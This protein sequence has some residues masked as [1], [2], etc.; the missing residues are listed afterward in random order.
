MGKRGPQPHPTALKLVRGAREDKINRDE[1]AVG[2]RAIPEPPIE[3]DDRA[4]GRWRDVTGLLHRAGILRTSDAAVLARY[5][6][7]W[8]QWSRCVEDVQRNGMTVRGARGGK[9]ANPAATHARA[10]S[11]HL[12][13]I[14]DRFGLSATARA[15]LKVGGGPAS[16]PLDD[17][18]R[19]RA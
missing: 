16:D 4:M 19:G 14:E 18:A 13:R 2:E 12:M 10:L 6:V 15:G 3:L 5:C 17:F 7:M 11:E 9:V 1:P 8:S